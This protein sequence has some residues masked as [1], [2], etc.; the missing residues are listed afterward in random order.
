VEFGRGKQL[1]AR[2]RQLVPGGCHTY[3]TGDD[4]HPELV[5]SLIARG[6]G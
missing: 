3:A 6:K 5:P 4:Q 1:A 2:L